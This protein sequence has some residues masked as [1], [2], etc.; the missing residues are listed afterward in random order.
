MSTAA[1]A[2]AFF[3]GTWR[4][5]DDAWTF[6]PLQPSAAWLRVTYGDP[7]APYGTAVF[8][9]ADG[10]KAFVYRDFHADGGYADLTTAGPGTD[11]TWTFTGHYY[12]ASGAAGFDTH[13]VYVPRGPSRY[14]RIF[15]M[16][17]D[18]ALVPT[19]SDV[20]TKAS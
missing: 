19:G 4:C 7:S 9:Y 6:A 12:P 5:K 2:L 20:C 17:R 16:L 18:G 11:G 13:I 1:A 10:M 14:E 15:A 3:I 8:G